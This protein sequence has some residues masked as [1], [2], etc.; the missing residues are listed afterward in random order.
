M[1]LT[2]GAVVLLADEPTPRFF[3]GLNLNGPAVTID[4]HLWDGADNPQYRSKDKAFEN[5]SIP[6]VPETDPERARMLRSSR[7]G[8]VEILLTDVPNGRYTVF[9]YVWEDNNAERYSLTLNGRS[10][11]RNYISG[12]AGVWDRHGPWPVEVRDGQIQIT[13]RG[14]AANV[15]GIEVWSGDYDGYE[16]ELLDDDVAFFESR[17]RPLL[18]QACYE[19]HSAD[20][21]DLAGDFRVDFRGALRQKGPHGFAVVPG[22]LERSRLIQAVRYNDADLQMPP[23]G[24]LT[25]E[26]IAILEDWVRR[27]APDP[28]RTAKPFVKKS[29]DV[30]KAREFWSLKPLVTP[31]IPQINDPLWNTNDIDRLVAAEWANHGA[32][33]MGLADRRTL[34]RRVTFDLIGLPPTPAELAE[35]EQDSSP[36]AWSRVVERLLASPHYG[37]RW[38]RHWMD[39]VRYADTAGDNSDYP[40]PQAYLYRNYI[41]DAFNADKPYDQFLTEQIAGDLLPAASDDESNEHL[42]ATG[43]LASARRFGSLFKD[44]PQHL[45]IEDTIDNLG[46]TVLGLTLSCARCH[47]H[48]FDPVTQADYYGL[49]GIFESTRYPFPGIELEKKPRDFVPLKHDGKPSDQLA[50]AVVDGAPADAAVQQR[51]DPSKPGEVIPRRFLEVLGAATLS[52]SA[53]Q[54]SGRLELARW[55]TDRENPLTA[56]VMVNRIWQQHFG[57]GL[58]KTPSDFGLRGQP[59]SHPALLDHL[60]LTFMNEDWSIKAMHRRI[61]HTRLYQLSSLDDPRNVAVDPNNDWLWKFSRRRL[62]AEALRDAMLFISGELDL[63]MPREPHPFPPVDQWEFTQHHPFRGQYDSRHR[64]IYLMTTRLNAL[65]F[66]V[67]FDG[68]DRNASTPKRDSSVTAIQSLYLLNSEFVHQQAQAFARRLIQSEADANAR[69]RLA[70]ELTIARPPTSDE[71]A[72]NRDFLEHVNAS[73]QQSDLTTE[74]RE[75]QR[76]ASLARVLFR[77]NEFLYVD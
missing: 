14:G 46:R 25:S 33:P 5:Q 3:R 8:D 51:G 45:T 58:V 68:A 27:G 65:P 9:V 47:D 70:Y 34:L 13:S 35:F 55:L 26:E 62:D 53:Q 59:P 41:I 1:V 77:M 11:L 43:Y 21:D 66:M 17:V 31:T 4:G 15:S 48:K 19:C 60:A 20:A 50:Y 75:Q 40:I 63:T 69:M 36:E 23:A 42:I 7:W 74:E 39:L 76:W 10:V 2:A 37:E 44:Y 67:S 57:M 72:A 29:I 49:Y 28:R 18:V 71:T 61:L 6:L 38:G 73:F 12:P 22:D 54:T 30:T 64:S 32:T 56:R 52:P 24:K 16:T